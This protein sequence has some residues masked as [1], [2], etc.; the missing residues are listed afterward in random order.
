MRHLCALIL[1]LATTAHAQGV[2]TGY[3]AAGP[4]AIVEPAADWSPLPC[5]PD[6]LGGTGKGHA[7]RVDPGGVTAW[8]W[9]PAGAAWSLRWGAW[10]WADL[11]PVVAG[12]PA[13]LVAADKAAAL[14]ALDRGRAI[15]EPEI[16]ALWC[17]HWSAM[18]ASQ[19]G[20]PAPEVWWV[21]K[22]PANANPPGTRPASHYVGGVM[23]SAQQRI[24][25]YT[26]CNPAAARIRLDLV[27]WCAVGTSTTL[28][29]IAARKP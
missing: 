11:A 5:L 24:A 7:T 8:L 29:A 25:E 17:P 13:A 19:P 20:V 9:C 4:A 15:D 28:Y 12:L 22:A 26:L 21:A 3:A 27:T 1:A 18:R 16:K 6:T 10:T 23:V 14:L 2:C